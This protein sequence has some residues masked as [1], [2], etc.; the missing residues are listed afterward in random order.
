METYLGESEN[1]NIPGS[2]SIVSMQTK[3]DLIC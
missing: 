2:R 1:N 3:P